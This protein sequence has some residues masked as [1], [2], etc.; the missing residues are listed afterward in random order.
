[1]KG[2]LI[3][4]ILFSVL[5]CAPSSRDLLKLESRIDSLQKQLDKSYTPGFGEIMSGIQVHHAKLWFA[6]INEN[7]E[8]AEFEIH[9]IDEGLEDIMNFNI[10]RP[11]SKVIPMINPALDSVR[12]AIKNM[13]P[14]QF[15][16]GYILLTNTCNE[17][18]KATNH[19]FNIV[20][21]PKNLPVVNQ[22]FNPVR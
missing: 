16:N 11:E 17:C 5:S 13:N 3:F 14:G 7:W 12:V 1:M 19:Q 4:P 15:K 6:G 22:D 8:L 9:E 20:T 2:T 21:V 10:D 18:H